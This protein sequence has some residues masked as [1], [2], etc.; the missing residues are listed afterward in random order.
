[1]C[2][3]VCVRARAWVGEWVGSCVYVCCVLYVRLCCMCVVCMCVCVCVYMLD[4]RRRPAL[5]IRLSPVPVS[6][7]ACADCPD[8]YVCFPA[9]V[10]EH[11]P[12]VPRGEAAAT[13]CSPVSL[14]TLVAPRTHITN[15][16][17]TYTF[18]ILIE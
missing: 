7:Y 12:S 13:T 16:R 4:V 9:D 11:H 2:V 1:M 6:V 5:S 18:P 10:G 14:Y 15:E 3:C 8:R 17:I